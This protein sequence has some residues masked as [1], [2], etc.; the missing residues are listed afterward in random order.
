MNKEPPYIL[1]SNKIEDYKNEILLLE[2]QFANLPKPEW[3]SY[4]KLFKE[5]QENILIPYSETREN[6]YMFC[7]KTMEY[8]ITDKKLKQS[9]EDLSKLYTMYINETL[10]IISKMDLK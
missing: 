6:F 2:Y 7:K 10:P 1:L 8:Y 4:E 5:Y 3:H 9:K